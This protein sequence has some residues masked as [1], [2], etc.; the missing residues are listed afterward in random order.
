[1]DRNSDSDAPP[2]PSSDE[3]QDG[4][5]PALYCDACRHEVASE[6][7]AC[8]H[9]GISFDGAGYFHRL[10]AEPPSD[11]FAFLFPGSAAKGR[12]TIRHR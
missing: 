6:A 3:A 10:A 8:A 1:M 5:E 12:Q 4:T 7:H 9:C 2:P 11:D